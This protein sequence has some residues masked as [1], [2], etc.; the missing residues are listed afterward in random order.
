MSMTIISNLENVFNSIGCMEQYHKRQLPRR[1][2]MY[3]QLP[4]S[5]L[6][7]L[8]CKILDDINALSCVSNS[9]N[10]WNIAIDLRKIPI[11]P[12]DLEIRLN[13]DNLIVSGKSEISNE[14]NGF[15]TLSVH[16]WSKE[17]KLDGDVKKDTI[18]AKM[19]KNNKIQITADIDENEKQQIPIKFD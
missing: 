13:G 17:I 12:K 18:K 14:K 6:D 11:E 8:P 7:V 4:I 15:K 2:R 3:R 10:E 1:K 16:N 19:D 9:D 5:V